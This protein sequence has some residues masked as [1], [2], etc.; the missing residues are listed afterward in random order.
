MAGTGLVKGD[1]RLLFRRVMFA[2]TRKQVGQPMR[3]RET[4]EHV[5]LYL[6]AF[7]AWAT[8]DTLSSLRFTAREPVPTVLKIN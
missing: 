6:K 1:P 4:R 8:G 5:T 7:N 3:R 2:H